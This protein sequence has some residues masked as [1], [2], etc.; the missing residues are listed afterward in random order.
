MDHPRILSRALIALSENA[1]PR[2]LPLQVALAL[3]TLF[4]AGL[5]ADFKG[6]YI[7]NI[8]EYRG[9]QSGMQ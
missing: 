2:C 7:L 8:P 1:C 4:V 6:E 5:A 3:A 9:L